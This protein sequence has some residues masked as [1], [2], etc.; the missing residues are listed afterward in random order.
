M[1]QNYF[2]LGTIVTMLGWDKPA[3]SA[4]LIASEITQDAKDW[5][6]PFLLDIELPFDRINNIQHVG[7]IVTRMKSILDVAGLVV[8]DPIF[9]YLIEDIKSNTVNEM[10]VHKYSCPAEIVDIS[11]FENQ[12]FATT[13]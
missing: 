5:Q 3:S 13:S 10:R 4:Y 2:Q 9:D 6:E 1:S 12:T 8:P 7:E 11:P